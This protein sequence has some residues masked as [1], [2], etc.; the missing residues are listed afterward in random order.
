MGH[1][2]PLT[3]FQNGIRRTSTHLGYLL[4]LLEVEQS[5]ASLCFVFDPQNPHIILETLRVELASPKTDCVLHN[6][7]L[8]T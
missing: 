8:P 4:G 2:V 6:F 5:L 1:S 7:T 3:G